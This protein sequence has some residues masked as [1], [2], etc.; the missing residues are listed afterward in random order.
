MTDRLSSKI[1]ACFQ[2]YAWSL[3]LA[4]A[5]LTPDLS[6]AQSSMTKVNDSMRGWDLLHTAWNVRQQYTELVREM[7]VSQADATAEIQKADEAARPGRDKIIQ[8]SN[9]LISDVQRD[10]R[11]APRGNPPG[12]EEYFKRMIQAAE[13]LK[14]RYSVLINKINS[15]PQGQTRFFVAK[16]ILLDLQKLLNA[17]Y[18]RTF[19]ERDANAAIQSAEKSVEMADRDQRSY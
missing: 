17:A 18:A 9:S 19:N 2:P 16:N 3:V 1:T 10:L 14:P 5:A 12:N 4:F 6:L 15:T 13:D 11:G 7:K 8:L